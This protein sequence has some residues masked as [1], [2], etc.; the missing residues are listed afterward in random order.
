MGFHE[1]SSPTAVWRYAEPVEIL[2]EPLQGV[3]TIEISFGV[4]WDEEHPVA[5]RI[6][7]WRLVELCGSV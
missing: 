6:Q 4:A 7:T 1:I 2:I 5:A 3:P